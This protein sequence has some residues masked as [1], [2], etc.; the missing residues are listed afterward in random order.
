MSED[1]EHDKETDSTVMEFDFPLPLNKISQNLVKRHADIARLLEIPTEDPELTFV[2]TTVASL[3]DPF[4]QPEESEQTILSV[5]CVSD[6]VIAL[7]Y[8]RFIETNGTNSDGNGSSAVPTDSPPT[9]ASNS[10]PTAVHPPNPSSNASKAS[11]APIDIASIK[12]ELS[13][14][15]FTII[16]HIHRVLNAEDELELRYVNNDEQHY[17]ENLHTWTPSEALQNE[18]FNLKLVYAVAC[19]L[20]LAIYKLF[21]PP[22]GDYNLTVNP[23][24]HYFLK[25]WKCHTNIILLGLEIDRRIEFRNHNEDLEEVTPEVIKQTLKG[26]SSIRYILAWI[27]NQNPSSLYEEEQDHSPEEE[28]DIENETLLNFIQPLARKK[29]NGGSL[30]IDMRLVI[31]A[32]LILNSGISFTAGQYQLSDKPSSSSDEASRRLNQSKKITEIGDILIDL[33]YDD[34]FD[35]DIRYIFEY[36]YEDSE[37]DWS[38]ISEEEI[39]KS[40]GE[41]DITEVTDE[42]ADNATSKEDKEASD[43]SRAIRSTD[44]AG[45]IEFDEK[46]RDWR[47][48]P[49]GENE[50]FSDW[51][52]VKVNEFEKLANKGDSDYFF[53]TWEELED[54]FD[55]LSTNTIEGDNEAEKRIGQ[56][57]INTISNAIR[58]EVDKKNGNESIT[59]DKIYQYWSSSA[60]DEA[61]RITQENNKLIVPIFN[62]TKFE[63]MLHNNSKLSRCLMDEMLMCKGYRRVL[64]WFMT[65]NLNLSAL[66]IDYVFELLAGL[67]ANKTRQEPYLFTRQGDKLV[68]S[69]VEQSMLLHE[70]LTNSSVY[71]S[72]TEGIE[73]EDGYKVVLAESIAKK[74]MTLLCL[75]VNQLINLNIINL[76]ANSNSESKNDDDIQDYKNELQV[77]LINWVGKLPEAR[78]L[79]FKIKNSNYES[80]TEGKDNLI[81]ESLKYRYNEKEQLALFEKYATLTTAEISE[82]LENND[83][84]LLIVDDFTHRIETHLHAILGANSGSTAQKSIQPTNLQQLTEDFRFFFNHF[85]TLCKIE[86]VAESL[87][88]EFENIISTGS[89]DGVAP[90]GVTSGTNGGP[91]QDFSEAEFN[92]EF[93]NGEGKFDSANGVVTSKS[94]K[95]KNKKKKKS[96]KK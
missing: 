13:M 56:V 57:V 80:T 39:E 16:R 32:L 26:S 53:A 76:S 49:R 58:I 2:F 93:L 86:Y 6:L 7:T 8:S 88:E 24:L 23:Y 84:N 51:F 35:E 91:K 27:I 72:A 34:R 43:V 38:D 81:D 73:I 41:T 33:E 85:N 50:K 29:V 11:A 82:D 46:G 17:A 62:I 68:F 87:F 92:S 94:T 9:T 95:K 37:A 69:E 54:T 10:V 59:P 83:H 71:L 65:H 3:C 67:R 12:F 42:A 90:V 18:D 63:L 52:L 66:L 40:N 15:Y 70:F 47:D 45:D 1:I 64:I 78:Q 31:I 89:T 21:K 28:N 61:I 4:T 96:K 48:L 30:S 60:S 25:L 75:M 5:D 20:L 79:F 36:E 74:Y 14:Q 55:F 77:L 44:E 22:T 19:V